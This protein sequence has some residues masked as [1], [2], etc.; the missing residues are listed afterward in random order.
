MNLVNGIVL[1]R[2]QN[3]FMQKPVKIHVNIQGQKPELC[4]AS[5]I[6]TYVTSLMKPR[7][8][9]DPRQLKMGRIHYMGVN[10]QNSIA[11]VA[12]KKNCMLHSTARSLQFN[13][14]Y[15]PN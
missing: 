8:S 15:P 3:D 11:Q 4:L 9:V 7:V 14:A 13:N 2:Q 10:I 6:I 12:K 5:G 1:V